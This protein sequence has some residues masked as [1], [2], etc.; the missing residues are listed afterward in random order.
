MGKKADSELYVIVKAKDL[1]NYIFTITE[2][3]PKKYRFT[4][5]S[6]LQN[7]A[8]NIVEYIYRAN[9]V[10]VK[11]GSDERRISVRKQYQKEAYVNLK[12]IDYMALMAREQGC[13][14]PKQYEQISMRAAEV[15]SL[16]I[17]WGKSD[18]NRYNRIKRNN[19]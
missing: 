3:S 14:L 1:V 11:D 8:L 16:L 15:T 7:T 17:G 13:I 6:R 4:F 12:V 2:K 10:F 9:M 19:S 5:I 18:V